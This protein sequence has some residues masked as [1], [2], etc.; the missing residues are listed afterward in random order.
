[1]RVGR[2]VVRLRFGNFQ[3]HILCRTCIINYVVQSTLT[4]TYILECAVSQSKINSFSTAG[5]KSSVRGRVQ[6]TTSVVSQATC[7]LEQGRKCLRKL[8]YIFFCIV[9]EFLH[10]N[11]SHDSNGYHK[12]EER[13]R[14]D[15]ETKLA[16]QPELWKS[17]AICC[18]DG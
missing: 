4:H 10:T 12:E 15:N 11:Q 8:Q 16:I 17:Q 18:S 2:W 5:L 14:V 7:L 9:Q 6:K 13:R 1:M 3:Q